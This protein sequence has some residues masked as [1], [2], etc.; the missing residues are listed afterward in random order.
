MDS[1]M[2]VSLGAMGVLSRDERVLV[3]GAG[4][5]IGGHLVGYLAAQ[6]FPV[7][8]AA[9]VRPA[10][11]WF[12]VLA[13]AESVQLDRSDA[14]SVRSAADGCGCVF[15][16]A[17]G[18]QDSAA[19]SAGAAALQAAAVAAGASCLLRAVPS[20]YVGN[21]ETG[22]VRADYSGLAIRSVRHAGV[23][24]SHGPWHGGQEPVPVMLSRKV[25]EALL[26]GADE[27]ELGGDGADARTF[28]HVDDCVRGILAALDSDQAEP[29]TLAGT[30]VVSVDELLDVIEEIAGVRLKRSYR[31]AGPARADA[32][33][34]SGAPPRRPAGW[35][36][37]ISLRDGMTSTYAWV[38]DQV[39]ARSLT[40][41][42]G[43]SRISA[44]GL[45]TTSRQRSR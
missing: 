26:A 22:S 42:R 9:D 34:A 43:Y 25:A 20:D 11:R 40:G 27:I 37:T 41:R 21:E 3:D 17:T 28:L 31:Q 35:E 29:V 2:R 4:G 36:P 5:F 24:G 8:R 33:N 13:R 44:S 39:S 16:L 6:G 1:Y 45:V 30:E 10:G 7:I 18:Q 32:D 19:A 23:Y 38:Y 12:Q 15:D 14:A